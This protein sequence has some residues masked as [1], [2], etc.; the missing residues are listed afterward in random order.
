M[1]ME[2]KAG[3]KGEQELAVTESQLART[4]GSGQVAVFATPMMIAGIEGTAA[5]SV[6][7]ALEEGQ[8]TVGTLINM[9]HVAATPPGMKVRFV[10]EL[11]SVSP[12]GRS[13]V[14]HVAAYDE[15]GLIGEGSHERVVV[16]KEKFEARALAKREKK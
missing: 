16:W 8:V 12:N 7:D 2:L 15:A 5:A 1:K 4:V 10:T 9:T 3:L 14:F 13:L 11:T 6:Q